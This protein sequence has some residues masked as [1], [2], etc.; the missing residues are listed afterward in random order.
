MN[1]YPNVPPALDRLF[2]SNPVFFVTIC[3]YQRRALLAT[4]AVNDAFVRFSRRAYEEHGIAVGR[5]VIM[6]DHIHL[7]ICGPN[8]FE[9]GRWI[10][11]LKQCL[12]KALAATA[13]PAG[14]RLQKIWQRRFFDHVL[15]NE[16]SYAQ[17]WNY[18]RDNPVRADFVEN[19]DDWPFAGEIIPIDRI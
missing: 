13:S 15:R 10:G 5:Y 4:D 6:P 7:F 3:T 9:L 14:R 17:K 16:E 1:K 11:M 18:V 19:A 12:E 2:P 8:D